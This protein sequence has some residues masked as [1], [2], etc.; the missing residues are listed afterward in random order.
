MLEQFEI[1]YQIMLAEKREMEQTGNI[2]NKLHKSIR[3]VYEKKFE[4]VL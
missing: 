3:D 2:K 1:M 4:T